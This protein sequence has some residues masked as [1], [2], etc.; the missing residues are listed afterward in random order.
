MLNKLVAFIESNQLFAKKNTFLIAASGGVDSVVLCHLF[1]KAK[2]DI[3]IAHCNFQL[4]KDESDEDEAYTKQLASNLNVSFYSKKFD[5][6]SYSKNN[7]ISIQIAA[8]NLRYEW[9]K[10][11]LTTHQFNY[12]ATAHHAS[13]QAETVLYNLT[14]GCGISGLRGIPLKKEN[15][16]RPLLFATKEEIIQYAQENNLE[17]REDTSNQ[18]NKYSRNLIRNQVIPKLKKIN[19]GFEETMLR[20]IDRYKSIETFIA[21]E[22]SKIKF[23]YLFQS[24]TN[25]TLNL[26]WLSEDYKILLQHILV[27]F[28]FNYFQFKNIYQSI[29]SS[30]KSFYSDAYQ[31]LIDRNQLFI[32]PIKEKTGIDII[33]INKSKSKFC[34]GSYNF[35]LSIQKRNTIK[36]SK[37]LQIAYLDYDKIVFPFTIR[38]WKESDRFIPLGMKTEKKLSDFMIDEK[39][40]VNLKKQIPIFISKNKIFWIAGF[41]IDDKF[42]ITNITKKVLIIKIK[43]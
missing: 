23:Q 32:S 16:I 5:I 37:S 21:A 8:R 15:I 40:P 22:V 38:N 18:K 41:R 7:K 10:S 33:T 28:G 31:L 19:T 1:S 20:N 4:R 35:F 17:W 36:I 2:Y 13:D 9:F 29:N 25:W 3:T 42:K 43:S 27:D 12:I 30:G 6:K 14:K 26:A 11:L 39:I 34:F 24:E